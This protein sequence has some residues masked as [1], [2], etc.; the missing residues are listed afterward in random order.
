M[1]APIADHA[2]TQATWRCPYKD[3]RDRCTAAFGCRNQRHPAAG[4]RRFEPGPEQP[5]FLCA[6]DDKLDYRSAWEVDAVAATSQD[7]PAGRTSERQR[8]RA[9]GEVDAEAA[10]GEMSAS[11]QGSGSVACGAER[12]S[13]VAGATLFDYADRAA[14][15]VPSS[16]A[17]TGICHECVVRVDAGIAA[18]SP[19][20]EPERFLQDPFRLACQTEVTDRS[21]DVA[22][23]PLR[24]SPRILTDG[25]PNGR[26]RVTEV[27]LRAA[28]R[29]PG[30]RDRFRGR[31]LGLAVDLGTT[32]VVMKVVDLEAE[33]TIVTA[34]FANPQGFAG[35]DIMNR[36][37][38]AAG[39]FTEELQHAVVSAIN[40]EIRTVARSC[41]FRRTS[42]TDMVVAGNPTM[43]DILFGL[44]VQELGQRPYRSSVEADFRAGRRATTAL[45]APARQ[46]GLHLNPRARVLGLPIIGSH[47]GADTVAC[48]LAIGMADAERPVMLVDVG[49]NT[50]V[51]VGHR[52]RLIAASCPAGP[53]FE[54]GLITYGMPAYDGAIESLAWQDGSFSAHTIGGAP[55]EGICGSGLI[56]LVAELRRHGMITPKGVFTADR[57]L[58]EIEVVPDRI[59]FSRADASALAQAKAANY[60]GQ[61]I[62]MRH[63]GVEPAELHRLYLA[64]GFATYVNA[65][66]AIEIGMLAP[67]P[68]DRIEKVGNA[69]V[70]GAR[71]ALLSEP[72]RERID[73]LAQRVEHVEL[74]LEADFFELF[75][76]GC[77]FEPMR[78]RPAARAR[79]RPQRRTEE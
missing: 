66:N 32:T 34:S 26:E 33:A 79:P 73:A 19:R 62:A 12:L 47:V 20:T 75:V 38:Y 65:R 28:D 40:T 21:A 77:R 30:A 23:Q 72:E 58:M 67:V 48:L 29:V 45:Q 16:C 37:S 2:T 42:V 57:R 10:N 13:P 1:L 70:E 11:D 51:V 44:D 55:P 50:E 71:I 25:S 53:A 24:R 68:V 69:A 7:R 15:R 78:L 59:T 63:F 56:D 27:E 3:R 54:G 60:C 18:L 74:E 35:S 76:D 43:R 52:D 49:T 22:F 4:D 61:V 39:S 9:G 8:R 5:R 6:G 64:G 36:I 14:T 46:L 17:R 41:G 31:E